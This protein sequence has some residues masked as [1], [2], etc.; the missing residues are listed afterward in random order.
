[1]VFSKESITHDQL[2]DGQQRYHHLTEMHIHACQACPDIRSIQTSGYVHV[3]CSRNIAK[4]DHRC[5]SATVFTI[6][7]PVIFNTPEFR[8]K[9]KRWTMIAKLHRAY[10]R[11]VQRIGGTFWTGTHH[12]TCSDLDGRRI[13]GMG[14]VG[15]VLTARIFRSGHNAKTRDFYA[16]NAHGTLAAVKKKIRDASTCDLCGSDFRQRCSLVAYFS[17]KPCTKREL[18]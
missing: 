6:L 14:S 12:G 16:R 15:L 4:W 18:N 8:L 1:M 11:V 5:S 3:N 17:N 10:M 7:V 2:G 13:A 9:Q